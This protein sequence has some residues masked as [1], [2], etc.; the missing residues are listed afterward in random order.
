[1]LDKEIEKLLPSGLFWND[2]SRKWLEMA[3]LLGPG[4]VLGIEDVLV[5]YRLTPPWFIP[6]SLSDDVSIDW[7]FASRTPKSLRLT[8]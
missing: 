3:K 2:T 8:A 4:H 1:M 5:K 6:I 7:R